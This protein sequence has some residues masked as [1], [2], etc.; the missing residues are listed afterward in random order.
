[1]S[2]MRVPRVAV[3]V[4]C[5]TLMIGCGR[6]EEGAQSGQAGAEPP[7]QAL[8]SLSGCIEAAP[9]TGHYVL[10]HVRFEPRHSGDPHRDTTTPGPHGITEGSWVRLAAGNQDLESRTG[11]RVTISGVITDSGQN[12]I[13]TAGSSGAVTAS[14]DP[15]Q[16]ASKDHH[17]DKVKSEAGRIARES[18]ANGT[19]AEVRVQQVQGT[20]ERCQAEARP[21]R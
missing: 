7:A 14:G 11:Q 4:M 13:G 17:S 20:G 15:S 2:K 3:P 16:A 9:G 8:V 19:A 1:M 12:T 18:M 10:R 21:E 5:A 6:S